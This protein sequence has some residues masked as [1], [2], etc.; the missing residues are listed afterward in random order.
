MSIIYRSISINHDGIT[1][2]VLTQHLILHALI[3]KKIEW[4][5][6][7]NSYLSASLINKY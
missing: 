7:I 5:S 6:K 2:P 4:K 1:L 3:E